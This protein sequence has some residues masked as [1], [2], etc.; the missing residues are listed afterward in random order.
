MRLY[1]SSNQDLNVKVIEAHSLVQR[2]VGL[3]KY[4]TLDDKT[5]LW[6]KPCSSI[7][8]FFMRF[9]IDCVFLN[10][11]M[12]VEAIVENIRPWRVVL[13]VWKAQSALEFKAGQ[14]RELHLK[15]GDQLY[16]GT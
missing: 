7:H 10:R 1:K 12:Q 8:T 11:Q 16:V 6:L 15:K 3:I 14:L 13:P 9:A 2:T 4:K 5:A